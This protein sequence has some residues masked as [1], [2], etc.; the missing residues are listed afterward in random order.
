MNLIKSFTDTDDFDNYII[1]D[2]YNTNNGTFN[3]IRRYLGE[4]E[5]NA[6]GCNI[7]IS[8]NTPDTSTAY[9]LKAIYG[10]LENTGDTEC[11]QY[12]TYGVSFSDYST[13]THTNNI[14]DKI[15]TVI[16]ALEA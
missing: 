13:P 9:I 11:L 4:S 5:Y 3:I 6:M 2:K 10:L 8:V 1:A 7:E 12:D 14:I 15:V 16:S